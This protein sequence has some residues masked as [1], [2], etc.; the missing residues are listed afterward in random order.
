[1]NT[2]FHL[3]LFLVVLFLY[4]HI[5]SQFKRSED[6]EIYEM[7]FA[8]NSH[9]QEVCDI[10]QPIMFEYKSHNPEFFQGVTAEKLMESGSYDIKVKDIEDYWKGEESVDYVV[11]PFQSAHTLMM[12][13]THAK[14]FSENNDMFIEDAGLVG[15]FQTN[16]AYL[17]PAFTAQTKYDVCIGS[18]QAT[19]PLRYHTYYRHFLCVNSGKIRVKMSPF[20]SA[21]YLY[22]VLDYNNYEFFS[23]V[24]VWKPQKKF[25]HEVDK[26][27]F[28]EFD[29]AD[30]SALYIPPYWFYSIQ[31]LDDADTVVTAFTYNTSMNCVANLPKWGL[32][33]LQQSNTKHSI[34]KTLDVPLPAPVEVEPV[35]PTMDLD[36]VD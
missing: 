23:P 16:D 10:K 35:T 4:I 24:N 9:L 17:K 19:T 36:Q 26:I 2:Y 12:T 14:Y 3:L 11:L 27:K 15:Q 20:K 30:G 32:Y 34:T 31:Y 33:F 1:M 6:L 28:L 13:D 7:D 22:P 5:A 29:V 8:T 25:L 21:K 18:K